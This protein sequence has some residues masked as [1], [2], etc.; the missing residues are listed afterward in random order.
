M[1]SS[2][3]E[4]EIY[5]RRYSLRMDSGLSESEVEAVAHALDLK[6]QQIATKTGS[7]DSLKVAVLTALH[8]AQEYLDLKRQH[9]R[10]EALIESKSAEWL[11]ALK[12]VLGK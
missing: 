3:I 4:V 1:N 9:D 10:N 5:D 2:N 8:L 11:H 12:R 7:P 6:M